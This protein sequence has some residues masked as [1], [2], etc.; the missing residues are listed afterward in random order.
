M[1]AF[2]SIFKPSAR[3]PDPL[4]MQRSQA[5]V[6]YSKGRVTVDV[7]LHGS[8]TWTRCA[9][10]NNVY[11]P[12]AGYYFGLTS[13]TG[14]LV[15]NHDIN[16]FRLQTSTAPERATVESRTDVAAEEEQA[17]A[18]EVPGDGN[19]GSGNAPVDDVGRIVEQSGVFQMLKRQAEV[20]AEKLHAIRSHLDSQVRGLRAHIDSI[21]SK[22]KRQEEELVQTLAHLEQIGHIEIDDALLKHRDTTHWGWAFAGLSGVM[23]A[24]VTM[25]WRKYTAVKKKHIL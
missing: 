4:A 23:C 18:D 17:A 25:M 10:V 14:D 9:D 21:T 19:S 16:L 12:T 6:R 11:V 24:G 1:L 3:V 15:D 13:S 2:R 5:K 20:H 8:V 22:I 7:N